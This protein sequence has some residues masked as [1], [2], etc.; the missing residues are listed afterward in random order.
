MSG[1]PRTAIGTYGSI[2]VSRARMKVFVAHTRFRDADGRLREVTASA[3]TRNRAIAELKERL[4]RRPGYGQGGQL[5]LRSPFGDLAELWLAELEQRD[6]S[7]GTKDN[8]R[9]DLRLHVRPFFE[10][11]TLGEITTGRVEIFLKQQA[12]VS[13]SRAKHTRTLLNQLFGYALRHDALARN[14]VEGT[15]PLKKPKGSPQAL[16]IEQIAAIRR[17]AAQWRT[18][19]DVKGPK[20]D[21]QVR[22]AIEVLLGTGMRPG[23]A[24]ALRPIDISETRTG[25]IAHVNGTIVSRKGRGTFRQDRPKTDASIRSISVPEFAAVVIRRRLERMDSSH[26]ERTIFH[27]RRGGPLTLHNLRRTFREFLALAGLEDSGITPR[28][29]R[30][31]SATVLARGLG[32]D[33]AATHLGHTST[34]ITE[35]HYIEPD[36]TIDL[37]PA[38]VLEATLRPVDPDGALLA[39]PHSDEE[40]QLL[41]QIDSRDDEEDRVDVA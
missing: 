39:R 23:E 40:E 4:Q 35:G 7:E 20:P 38:R 19:P 3:T 25:M 34:A 36:R 1:R 24:L 13:Y 31:T 14:P 9:D 11:Y 8:Y 33:A 30:R 5:S 37:M 32:A 10:N 2:S 17:A 26:A 22:D 12:A 29:Y 6:I 27:N 15:S 28:W 18:G 16:T 21:G 41:D